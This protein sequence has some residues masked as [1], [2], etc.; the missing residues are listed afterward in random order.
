MKESSNICSTEIGSVTQAIKAQE[1]L[2]KYAIPTKIIKTESSRRGC[3][4]AL[5]YA[6]SQENN[7]NSLLAN[8]KPTSRYRKER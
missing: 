2:A 4:Y 8:A 3:V 5:T 6:C 7:V 1:L